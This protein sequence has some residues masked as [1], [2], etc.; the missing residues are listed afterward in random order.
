MALLISAHGGETI[1]LKRGSECSK[2]T[3]KRTYPSAV[4]INAEGSVVHGLI[5]TGGNI[6]WRAGTITAPGG[7][8]GVAGDGYGALLRGAVNVRFAGV[9]FT[10]AD[11]GIVLDR[12][13]HIDVADSRFLQLG[14]DGI[15]ANASQQLVISGNRFGETNA[16]PTHCATATS[17]AIGLSRRDC[18][19]RG[20]SWKDGTHPDAVQMRNGVTDVLLTSNVVEGKTQGLTQMDTIGDAP[21]ERIRIERNTITTD[22]GHKATLKR[23][24]DCFIRWN[25]IKRPPGSTW[26]AV[27]VPGS[28]TVCGNTTEKPDP[29]CS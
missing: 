6:R 1:N 24:I 8:H 13:K 9:L 10:A 18:I 11:R 5:I 17:I 26:K 22:A 21:L 14:S 23:C 15:I 19:A 20:G 12:A 25:V 27:I 16:T 3:I 29:A 7:I 2:L 28:A 4:T